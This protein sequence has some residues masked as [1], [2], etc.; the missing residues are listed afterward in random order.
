MV[1]QWYLCRKRKQFEPKRGI[2]SGVEETLLTT[3]TTSTTRQMIS[4]SKRTSNYLNMISNVIIT[5]LTADHTCTCTSCR[6]ALSL[7]WI[8]VWILQGFIRPWEVLQTEMNTVNNVGVNNPSSLWMKKINSC[9]QSGLINVL[10]N[11][12][13]TKRMKLETLFSSTQDLHTNGAFHP[14]QQ[15]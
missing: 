3:S 11:T 5:V 9:P 10:R 4:S 6:V 7:I 2:S 14:R 1:H 13:V 15:H 8:L 12:K